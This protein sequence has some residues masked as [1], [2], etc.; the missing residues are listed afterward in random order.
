MS[1]FLSKP[2]KFFRVLARHQDSPTRKKDVASISLKVR[3]VLKF[4]ILCETVYSKIDVLQSCFR[5]T[6]QIDRQHAF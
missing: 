6:L 5:G 4:V 1:G 3:K 2:V